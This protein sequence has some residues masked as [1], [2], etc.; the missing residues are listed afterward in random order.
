MLGSFQGNVNLKNSQNEIVYMPHPLSILL[1]ATIGANLIGHHGDLEVDKQGRPWWTGS[2][3]WPTTNVFSDHLSVS[4]GHKVWV[5]PR[6]CHPEKL[7][8][9]V[10][11]RCTCPLFILLLAV[12]GAKL[13]SPHGGLQVDKNVM[14]RNW[15][16]G[17]AVKE[18]LNTA[19]LGVWNLGPRMKLGIYFINSLWRNY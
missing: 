19:M 17:M 9:W 6:K 5:I 7:P 14:L 1:L 13:I 8:K 11:D 18:G 3:E 15:L 2:V 4:Q 12:I 16:H 10:F